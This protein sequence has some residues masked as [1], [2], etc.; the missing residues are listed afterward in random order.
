[1]DRKAPLADVYGEEV[2]SALTEGPNTFSRWGFPQGQGTL[3]GAI[4]SD[5]VVPNLIAEVLDGTI[6]AETA[7]QE[8]Q[9]EVT[10]LQDDL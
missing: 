6:D 9:S 3:V 1:V 5:L 4:Y 8:A 10:S 7:A 2:V